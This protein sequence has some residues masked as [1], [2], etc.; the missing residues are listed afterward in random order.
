MQTIRHNM[1]P[2]SFK[3]DEALLIASLTSSRGVS[4]MSQFELSCGLSKVHTGQPQ[5]PSS[6]S[7]S[8]TW[9]TIGWCNEMELG[10][11]PTEFHDRTSSGNQWCNARIIFDSTHMMQWTST[12]TKLRSQ[13]AIFHEV[14]LCCIMTTDSV[15]MVAQKIQLTSRSSRQKIT[16]R[17]WSKGNQ[18]KENRQRGLNRWNSENSARV[19]RG[20]RDL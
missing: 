11:L 7:G 19:R 3:G 1:L 16:C 13:S 2:V 17:T 10:E 9:A 6:T 5:N 15:L 14:S 20:K 12:S 4:Q 18:I 8:S